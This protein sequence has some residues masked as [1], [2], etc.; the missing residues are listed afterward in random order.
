EDNYGNIPGKATYNAVQGL[1]EYYGSSTFLT[2][3]LT[4]EA[5]KALEAPVQNKQ[6]FFL[7]LSHYAVHTPLQADP[8]FVQRYLDAGLDEIEAR[9]ASMIEGMD[10]SLGDV[11]NFLE[12]N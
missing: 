9:Y 10:K 2:E 4:L 8:R 3:A 5:L 7:Y 1:A 12:K 6:P 11:L